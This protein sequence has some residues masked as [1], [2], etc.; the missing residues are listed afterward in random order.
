MRA[1]V[2]RGPSLVEV[3]RVAE[4][5]IVEPTDALVQVTLAAICGTDLHAYR[6]DIDGFPVGTVLGHE[7]VGTVLALGE[8]VRGLR[9]GERVV[10]S[11]L[12]ACG[13]CWWCERGWHYQCERASLFGYGTVVGEYT[14]GGQ[15]ERVRVPFA[16]V[17]LRRVDPAIADEDALPI[18]DVLATA[19]MAL[20]ECGPVAGDC[21]AVVGCGPV[22]LCAVMCAKLRGTATIVAVDPHAARRERAAQLGAVAVAPEW[23]LET[24]R[25]HSGGRGADAAVEAVGSDASLAS[26]IALVRARGAV[27]AVGAH[28]SSAMAFSTED[29]FAREL[30]VK[31]VVGDPIAVGDELMALVASGALRPGAIV[32]HR[33]ALDAAPAAYRLFDR[34]EAIKVTLAP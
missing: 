5:A 6:G 16:E 7:F 14:P 19:H 1:V 18:G 24:V 22:G 8:Q 10:A 15:A 4:P 30:S 31:F 27:V 3:A 9:V 28:H 23:A 12:I 26:A 2:W 32:S 29:A 20:A 17:V 25:A 21:I 13:R 11:D 33:L 34:Q